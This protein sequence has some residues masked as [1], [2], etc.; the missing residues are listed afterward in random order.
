MGR[1][2]IY[3]GIGAPVI[4]ASWNVT[5]PILPL[6]PISP[7]CP[8]SPENPSAPL[9]PVEPGDPRRPLTNENQTARQITY[10]HTN[11]SVKA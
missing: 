11:L 2:G 6:H 1:G 4:S 3:W 7:G 8:V 10:K 5:V 9:G